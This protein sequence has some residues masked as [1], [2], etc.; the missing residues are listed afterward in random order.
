MK[1]IAFGKVVNGSLSIGKKREFIRDL[2]NFEGKEV[3]I[4]IEKR[5]KRRSLKQNAYYWG[6]VVPMCKNGLL[7]AGYKMTTEQVHEYLKANFNIVEI[8][9][10]N[11]GEILKSVGSTSEMTTSQMMDYFAE[12]QR[13]SAEYLGVQIPEP[14]EQMSLTL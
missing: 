10:E 7:E 13:W 8:V 2:A 14:N 11:T 3:T 1:L 5:K 12:I 9:N 6:V 4:T